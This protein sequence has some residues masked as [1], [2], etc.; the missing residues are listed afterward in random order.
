MSL[1]IER[2]KNADQAAIKN[3]SSNL[4][5]EPFDSMLNLCNLAPMAP[6]LDLNL[7]C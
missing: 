5:T 1:T 4:S 3:P 6:R 7:G 2:F